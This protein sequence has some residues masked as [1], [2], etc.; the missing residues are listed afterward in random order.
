MSSRVFRIFCSQ[1]DT[2]IMRYRK[3]GSGSLIRI[4]LN[5]IL[6]PKSFKEY[7]QVTKKS[8]IPPFDCTRCGQRIGAPTIHESGNRPAYRLIKG[9]FFK[10]EA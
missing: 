10:K 2:F 9:S 5:Q 6:E 7:K 3:E 4:Y 1:C 8:K